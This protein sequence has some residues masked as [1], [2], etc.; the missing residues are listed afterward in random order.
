MTSRVFQWPSRTFSK[1]TMIFGFPAQTMFGLW[2]LGADISSIWIMRSAFPSGTER[3]CA[4]L[5]YRH[6]KG[7]NIETQPLLH[8]LRGPLGPAGHRPAFVHRQ[9]RPARLRRR[10][11][12]GQT[13]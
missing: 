13:A 6:L 1:T 7:I 2:V 9:G 8:Q 10:H 3:A 12:R 11:D 5:P 4:K